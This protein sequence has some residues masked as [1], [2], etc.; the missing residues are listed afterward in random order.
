[1]NMNTEGFMIPVIN[2]DKCRQCGKCIKICPSLNPVTQNYPIEVKGCLSK[3]VALEG[4]ASGGAFVSIARY[5]IE[6]LHVM[7]MEQF[8]MI[9]SI[10]FIRKLQI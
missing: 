8:S 1:M 2:H 5:F 3:D 10:A 4:S 7:C 9:I 6:V